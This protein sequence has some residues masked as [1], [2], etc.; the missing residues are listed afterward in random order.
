MGGYR[1]PADVRKSLI[2]PAASDAALAQPFRKLSAQF[3]DLRDQ[4]AGLDWA[5]GPGFLTVSTPLL[6]TS[7]QAT[8]DLVAALTAL[9][10][11]PY[12]AVPG[13]RATLNTL[14]GAVATA[15]LAS[16]DLAQSIAANPLDG[17]S[18]PGS[19][20]D[21]GAIRQVRH[22]EARIDIKKYLQEATESFALASVC[23]G[24]AASGITRDLHQ[25]AQEKK[26]PK[27]N[28]GQLDTLTALARDGGR[29]Y[30]SGRIGAIKIQAADGTGINA[31]TFRVFERHR[32]VHIDTSTSL[33]Q[34][35]T[36]TVTDRA[37]RLLAQ[38]RP[39]TPAVSR[40]VAVRPAAPAAA[41]GRGR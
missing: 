5:P 26:L 38:P 37:R 13:S 22:A 25:A 41:A 15:S 28:P 24:Y 4:V 19:P 33:Y 18:L 2:S 6:L 29:R 16:L 7:Q 23:C 31:A 27:L 39:G 21:E 12:T 30:E 9:S 11:S 40:P 14:T 10:S 17:L 3:A 34:G 36:V 8:D 35:Q 1:L 32:L 20:A